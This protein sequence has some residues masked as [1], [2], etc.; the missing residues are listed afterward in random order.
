M[1]REVYI[2]NYTTNTKPQD[3][4]LDV[5]NMLHKSLAAYTFNIVVS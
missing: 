4:T 1:K 3:F 2:Y 5:D